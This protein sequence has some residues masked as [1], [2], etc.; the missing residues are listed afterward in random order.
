MTLFTD[1]VAQVIVT[2]PTD[3]TVWRW[4]APELPFLTGLSIN[5][6]RG[7][8]AMFTY[9]ID[10]TYEAGIKFMQLPSPFKQGNLVR[11]RIGYAS[12]GWTPWVSGFMKEGGA[13]ISVDANGVSG[14]ITV[15]GMAESYTYDI[16]KKKLKEAGWDYTKLLEVCAGGMGMDIFIT[17]EAAGSLADYLI[18]GEGLTKSTLST[19][20]FPSHILSKSYYDIVSHVCKEMNLVFM[21]STD[22]NS[23]S[24]R[25][26]KIGTKG[27]FA[28]GDMGLIEAEP[29]TYV[30]RGGIDEEANI[31]PCLSWSPEGDG[32]ATWL[33]SK[34]D[35]AAHGCSTSYILTDS[36]E[37]ETVV[38]NPKNQTAPTVGSVASNL[39]VETVVEGVSDDEERDETSPVS[40][41]SIAVQD[42]GSAKAQKTAESRQ[43]Q[44]NAA[45][46][47]VIT[48]LGL[49]DEECGNKCYLGGAGFVYD[50][51][52]AIDKLTHSYGPGSWEMS[53]VVHRDGR[54][55]K[56]GDEEIGAGGQLE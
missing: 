37:M 6:E 52:Y 41:A 33:S 2:D 36:G 49:P 45:Q 16:D 20:S 48:S 29:K 26:L 19:D 54:K 35:A 30:I 53:L 3:N 50:G 38:V 4:A 22:V 10:M 1:P 34:P 13:G 12:G 14:S 44:G 28:K 24:G 40:H 18:I 51:P 21:V 55:A 56:T 5:Y 11:A 39:P 43:G 42:G 25:V 15:T 27:E 8:V 31:Y 17:T 23:E 46:K 7:R 47:G 9:S 32:V